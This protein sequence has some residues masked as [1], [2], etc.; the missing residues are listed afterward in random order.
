M[1]DPFKRQIICPNCGAKNESGAKFC[2]ECGHEL[3]QQEDLQ[4]AISDESEPEEDHKQPN[5]PSAKKAGIRFCAIMIIALIVVGVVAIIASMV[6]NADSSANSSE[7]IA[8]AEA[9]NS[10]LSGDISSGSDS[11]DSGQPAQTCFYSSRGFE[12]GVA[13]VETEPV[14]SSNSVQWACIDTKGKQ[15]FALDPNVTPKSDFNDGVAIIEKPAAGNSSNANDADNKKMDSVIDK[16]GTVVFPK[17]G[18]KNEYTMTGPYNGDVFAQYTTN[19][20]D[21]TATLCG[22]LDKSGNWRIKPS[23]DFGAANG[24]E[25]FGI[26]A[27]GGNMLETAKIWYDAN[28]HEKFAFT[29]FEYEKRMVKAD[30][31]E[32][33]IFLPG[34]DGKRVSLPDSNNSY[35]TS[36]VSASDFGFHENGQGFY[37]ENGNRV[38][39]MSVH[40]GIPIGK[41]SGGYCTVE[42][43]NPQGNTFYTIIDKTGKQMFEPTSQKIGEVHNGL[44]I[45]SENNKTGTK[46]INMQ[47]K[48]AIALPDGM[49]GTDFSDDG[50]AE[51]TGG[52]N[53][54]NPQQPQ[55]YFI[56]TKGE[57]AF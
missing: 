22:I 25:N 2:G 11:S 23:S 1:E 46:Y 47:G 29:K 13:W 41:F 55:V 15:L 45:I 44:A 8:S 49:Q 16:T 32:G 21:K 5:L 26:F 39:D 31:S 50:L 56:N 17:S 28:T 20:I 38:I 53:L 27:L 51:V 48:V 7:P 35:A 30:Y 18:D 37:D 54:S 19:T 40:N 4:L 52:V 12:N 36:D 42:L 43:T 6:K 9:D 33:L 14:N 24:N 10:S 34:L 3:P 57:P